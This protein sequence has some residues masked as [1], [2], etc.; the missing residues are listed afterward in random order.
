MGDSLAAGFGAIPVTQGDAY[1][2]YREG[3]FDV[4]TNTSFANAGMPKATSG[5][6]LAF[7]VPE[8]VNIFP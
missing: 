8:A 1:L 4:M 7:Q 3:T 6:V 2:L 5:D